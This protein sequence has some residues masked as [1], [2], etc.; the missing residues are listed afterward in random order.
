ML[1]GYQPIT[2]ETHVK[3]L[4]RH[5][6]CILRVFDPHLPDKSLIYIITRPVRYFNIFFLFR[7]INAVIKHLLLLLLTLPAVCPERSIHLAF[8]S[9]LYIVVDNMI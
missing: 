3:T 4:S 2:F 9:N 5:K 6:R 7:E 8:L 1:P